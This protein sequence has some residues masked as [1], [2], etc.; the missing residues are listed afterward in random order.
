MTAQLANY[1][2]SNN[3]ILLKKHV[4]KLSTD[5]TGLFLVMGDPFKNSKTM[6]GQVVKVNENNKDL[7][8]NDVVLF[9]KTSVT[10]LK[11]ENEDYLLIK[12]EDVLAVFEQ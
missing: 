2:V 7:L 4:D 1:S 11:L 12:E 5:A 9:E 10:E 6:K 3:Y 8:V